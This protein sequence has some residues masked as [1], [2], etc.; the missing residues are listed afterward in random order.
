[1]DFTWTLCRQVIDKECI[2]YQLSNKIGRYAPKTQFVEV[3][4]NGDFIGLY[5]LMEKIKRGKERVN[6]SKLS[7][8][9]FCF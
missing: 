7:A 2:A 9:N 5:I 4:T 3:E 8:K 1:M 6:V